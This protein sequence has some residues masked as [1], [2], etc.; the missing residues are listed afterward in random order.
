MSLLTNLTNLMEFLTMPQQPVHT[1]V[2]ASITYY[3][4]R[5]RSARSREVITAGLASDV[6]EPIKNAAA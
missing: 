4:S 1:K 6:A 2:E 5:R 3:T